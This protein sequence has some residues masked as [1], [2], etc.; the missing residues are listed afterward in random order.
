MTHKK[1]LYGMFTEIPPHYDLINHIITWGRDRGWRLKAVEACLSTRPRKFLD[2][3][4]GTADLAITLA[5]KADY[6]IEIQALDFSQP[7]LDIAA[8]KAARL[9]VRNISFVQ[10]DASQLPFP[11]DNFDCLSVSF[12]FRNLTYQNPLAEKHLSEI[13]RVLKPGARC[14][15]VESSQPESRL[16]RSLYH[17]YMRQYVYRS[18]SLISGNRAAYRY[19][20]ESTCRYYSPGELRER[21]IQN[22]F[23]SVSYHPLLF[24]AAGI[25]VATK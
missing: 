22:G 11:S 4:C 1:P 14:V 12:A 6:E 13:R 23:T 3:C 24:G 16:I 8:R 10:G 18:G 7:M 2:L 9:K 21:L 25:Y 15:I 17:F 20:A 5:R 19:L